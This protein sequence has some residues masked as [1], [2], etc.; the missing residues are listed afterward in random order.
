MALAAFDLIKTTGVSPGTEN[1]SQ[2]HP[3]YLNVDSNSTDTDNNSIAVPKSG[4]PNFSFEQALRFKCTVAPNGYCENFIT[5]GPPYQPD[6]D[7]DPADKVT[8]Y[9]GVSATY[10]QPVSSQSSIATTRQDTNYYDSEHALLLHE[11]QITAV[12]Q[13]TNLLY[14]QLQVE[15]GAQQGKLTTMTRNLA[16]DEV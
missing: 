14:D 10:Y 3:C 7:R 9:W 2:H 6:H 1:D 12:G 15:L 4:G 5:W 11:G 16:F 13:E 8:V